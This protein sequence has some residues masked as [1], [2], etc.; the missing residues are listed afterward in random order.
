[1][2]KS[3]L[4]SEIAKKT[5][6]SIV[7]AKNFLDALKEVIEESLI[8]GGDVRIP[9]FLTITSKKVPASTGRNP[10][11]G[12]PIK[13]AARYRISIKAGKSLKDK[14]NEKRK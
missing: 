9:G 10:K 11:D 4:M 12:S 7:S 1:M 14:V 3:A 8:K 5:N 13:I 2:K 6:S